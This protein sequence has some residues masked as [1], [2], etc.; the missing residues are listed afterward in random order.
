MTP[1]VSPHGLAYKPTD[2]QRAAGELMARECQAWMEAHENEFRAMF[3]FVRA[4]KARGK[5]GRLRDRVMAWA[6]TNGMCGNFTNGLWAGV[7]RYMVIIDPSLLEVVR[8]ADSNIDAW[9][10][11]PVTWMEGKC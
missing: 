2:E 3:A 11:Y 6:F 7:V 1:M 10:L 5:V 8:L 4:L 9:G